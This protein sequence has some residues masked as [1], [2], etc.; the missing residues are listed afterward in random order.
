MPAYIHLVRDHGPNMLIAYP[1]LRLAER[2]LNQS[3][4]IDDLIHEDCLDEEVITDPA[5]LT[6]VRDTQK[7]ETVI[8]PECNHPADLEATA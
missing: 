4:F 2:A 6:E 3:N 5:R 1:S 7:T 8:P